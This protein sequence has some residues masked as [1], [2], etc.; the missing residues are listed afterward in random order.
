MPQIS[1]CTINSFLFTGKEADPRDEHRFLPGIDDVYLGR[2]AV[3]AHKVF[4]AT[5]VLQTP[6]P[7]IFPMVPREHSLRCEDSVKL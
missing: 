5:M 2:R 1:T 7:H 3:V 6:G 4:L